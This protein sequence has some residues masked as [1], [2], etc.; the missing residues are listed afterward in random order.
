[1]THEAPP[2]VTAYLADVVA[3]CRDST[4]AVVS[5]ITFG[6]V[7]TASYESHA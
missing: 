4:G 3:A 6:S 1:M 7:N 5:L 2:T